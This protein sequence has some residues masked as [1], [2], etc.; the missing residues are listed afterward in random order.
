MEELN[1]NGAQSNNTK[2]ILE[3]PNVV[4]PKCGSKIFKECVVLKKISPILAGTPTEQ[5]FPIPVY[6]CA[7][8]GEIP[9]EYKVK[10]NFDLIMG[11]NQDKKEDKKTTSNIIL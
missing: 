2:M 1:L 3:S 8:C 10:G 9:E 5:M 11:T 4:C 7:T 6:V